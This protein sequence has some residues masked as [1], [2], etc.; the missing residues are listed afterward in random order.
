MDSQQA[1]KA[2]ETGF[3]ATSLEDVRR[4]RALT[5]GATIILK[6]VP[7]HVG[8]KGNEEADAAARADLKDMPNPGTVMIMSYRR[9]L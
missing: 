5:Q 7:G 1:I 6:W 8:V 4:F 3:S 2:L 9:T